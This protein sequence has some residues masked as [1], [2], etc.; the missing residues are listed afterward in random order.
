[1]DYDSEKTEALKSYAVLANC[2]VVIHYFNYRKNITNACFKTIE[3]A[4]NTSKLGGYNETAMAENMSIC[5][6]MMH[7]AMSNSRKCQALTN[8]TADQCN[9]WANQTV[10]MNRIKQFDC[11]AKKTQ[12]LVTAHKVSAFLLHA[13]ACLALAPV[14]NSQDHKLTKIQAFSLAVACILHSYWLTQSSFSSST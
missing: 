13:V 1:M 6:S 12:K 2:S 14:S 5:R 9:C 11:Q 8:S 3:V 7:D 10:L 4:C